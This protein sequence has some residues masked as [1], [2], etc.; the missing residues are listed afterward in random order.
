MENRSR[1]TGR[2]WKG[3]WQWDWTLGQHRLTGGLEYQANVSQEM[4][5]DDIYPVYHPS[6]HYEARDHYRA[7]YLQDEYTLNDKISFSAGLRYDDYDGLGSTVNPR[8]AVI[9][10][11]NKDLSIKGVMARAFRAPSVFEKYYEDG[12]LLKRNPSGLDAETIQ[13][14]EVIFEYRMNPWMRGE[15]SLYN[16]E[17]KDLV[18]F[19]SDPVDNIPFYDNLGHAKTRGVEFQVQKH[20]E[21][22][23]E[24]RLGYAWQDVRDQDDNIRL[25]GSPPHLLKWRGS[26]PLSENWRLAG[27]MRYVASSYSHHDSNVRLPAYTLTDITL[28]GNVDEHWQL[29]L[30]L[31]NVFDKKYFYPLSSDFPIDRYAGEGRTL[32]LK[33]D[34]QF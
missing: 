32:R 12:Y 6:F 29:G 19:N 2:A 5:N 34:Y 21:N 17:I 11:P 4:H 33:V 13:A 20:W 22:G 23:T 26:Y 7:A 15:L 9:Y 25:S 1:F 10:R 24:M 8:L 14:Y 18:E 16:Y 28:S 30:S 3:E 27:E 31:Y